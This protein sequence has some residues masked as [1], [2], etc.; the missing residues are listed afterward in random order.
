MCA[1]EKYDQLFKLV[2]QLRSAHWHAKKY[3]SKEASAKEYR[4]GLEVDKLLREEHKDR[5]SI[6]K[7]LQ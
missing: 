3:Y 2:N 1:Q 6:K 7:E 4:I 5:E